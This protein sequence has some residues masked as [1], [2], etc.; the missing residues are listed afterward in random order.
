MNTGPALRNETRLASLNAT[1]LLDAPPQAAFD[2]LTQIATRLLDIPISTVTLVDD[3]RQFFVSCVGVDEP[4]KTARGTPLSH[5]LCQYVVATREPLIIEDS[6][7]EPLVAANLAVTDLGIIA[8]AGIPLVNSSGQ[9]LGSFCAMDTIPRHWREQDIQALETLAAATINEIELRTAA[10][11]VADSEA[12]FRQALEDVRAAA[13]ILDRDGRVSFANDFFLE[14]TGWLPE[15]VVGEDWFKFIATNAGAARS[16][17]QRDVALGQVEPANESVVRTAKGD[18]RLLAWGNTILRGSDGLVTGMAGIAQDVTVEREAARLKN[19]LIALVSHELRNPLTSINGA[20]KLVAKLASDEEPKVKQLV[21]LAARNSER[22]LRLV[23]DLLDIERV[24]SGSVALV[25]ER[26]SAQE[27]MKEACDSVSIPAMERDIQ[28]EVL[29]TDA[30]VDADH[31]RLVQVLANLVGN[32]IKFSASS[33]RID[34]SAFT[35]P[36]G[37]AMFAVQDHGRGIPPE[38]ID[39]IFDRFSQVETADAKVLGG[40]GL[41]LAICKAIVEQHGGRIWVEN[42]ANGGSTFRFTIPPRRASTDRAIH[43]K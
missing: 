22:M 24:S 33:E 27:M 28:L 4:W 38:L 25:R 8:Y 42:N 6:R 32:A 16:Q 17:F 2:R 12:R 39:R 43:A 34:L 20:L 36:D 5:S 41:G 13:V 10:R 23:N 19:E 31:D 30:I 3:K 35:D 1:G 11:V 14:L 15:Q 37:T 7:K 40:T 9:V 21:D 29:P 26:M 18:H